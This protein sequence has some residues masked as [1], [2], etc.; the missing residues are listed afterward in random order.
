[1]NEDQLYSER[2]LKPKAIRL[3]EL[4]SLLANDDCVKVA[5]ID[6]DGVLRGK[7]MSKD[8]FLCIAQE[9]F[10][11]ASVLFAWD[12]QDQIYTEGP[13]ISH[14]QNGY[15]D[16]LAVPDLRS[17]RRIPWEDDV[18]FF[19]VNFLDPKTK[20]SISGCPRSLLKR[21]AQKVGATGVTAMAGV[22]YEFSHFQLPEAGVATHM[23]VSDKPKPLEEGKFGYSIARPVHNKAY[24]Y[25]IFKTC[26]RFQCPLEGWHAEVGPGMYEAA[27]AFDEICEM[28][29]RAALFKLAV[30]SVAIKHSIKPSFMAK[31][32]ANSPGCSSHVHISLMD[33]RLGSDKNLLFRAAPDENVPMKALRDL[34]DIG[35]HFLAG[36]L[37]SLPSILPLLAPTVNSYKRLVENMW[38]PVTVSWGL[39]HRAASVRVIMPPTCAP[40]ATRFE[41]RVPSADSNGALVLAAIFA[42]GWYGV[43]EKL[44]VDLLPLDASTADPGKRLARNL[45]EA[46]DAMSAK[47]SI[48]R[49]LFGDEFVDHYAGSRYHEC[50]LWEEAVTDWEVKRYLEIV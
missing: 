40:E 26:G 45:R 6:I 4:A 28:A 50:K 12:L 8:K 24:Y 2:K 10:G 15:N 41:V 23:S 21:I 13:L 38:A 22:E 9:G 29:D 31:P 11:F 1:M 36:I 25:D 44:D 43:T 48:A 32:I 35:R 20:E 34:S 30:K 47:D 33:R 5:G 18:P 42:A 3:D 17:F 37:M 14:A 19:L 7:L 49:K 16:L 46:T 39:E 27:L